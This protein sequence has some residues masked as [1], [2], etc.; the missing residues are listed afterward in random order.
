MKTRV[1]SALVGIAILAAVLCFYDTPVFLIAVCIVSMLA[2]YEMLHTTKLVTNKFVLVWSVI[3]AG[4]IPVF[5]TIRSK[6]VGIPGCTLFVAGLCLALLRWHENFSVQSLATA[7][8]FSILV[9]SSISVLLV[10]RETYPQMGIFYLFL[11]ILGAWGS[12]TGAYF[13]GRAFGKRKLCPDISP[14]KTVEG[15]IGGIISAVLCYLVAGIIFT[16]LTPII[17]PGYTLTV[18][19]MELLLIAPFCSASGVLGDLFASVIKRQTGIK[20]YGNIMPGHGGVMDRF[21]SV[22]FVSPV[23]FLLIRVLP[24]AI[25]S[26]I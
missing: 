3:F 10:F 15:F 11:V 4:F 5:F 23:L 16:Y 20:D 19:Y 6:E 18:N 24:P 1:I 21:D 13:T 2:V 7:F 9:P 22:L 17:Y 25:I 8:T 12:D 26:V 14:N